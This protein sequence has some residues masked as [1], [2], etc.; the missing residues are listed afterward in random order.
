MAG[1]VSAGQGYKPNREA[2]YRGNGMPS[3][4]GNKMINDVIFTTDMMR[5]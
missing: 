4:G 5:K 2:D 1:T 3:H